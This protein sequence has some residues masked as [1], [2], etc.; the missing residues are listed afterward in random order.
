M[1]HAPGSSSSSPAGFD[2]AAFRSVR[3]GSGL[4]CPRCQGRRV[5]RWG[6]SGRRRRYRCLGCGRTFSDFTGTPLAYLKRIDR[7]P[8]YLRCLERAWPVRGTAL[9]LGLDPCTAF[10]WR[11]RFL[12]HLRDTDRTALLGDVGLGLLRFP[13]SE[14]GRRHAPSR[15]RDDPQGARRRDR[16]QRTG[17]PVRALPRRSVPP[18]SVLPPVSALPPVLVLVAWERDGPIAAGVVG[19]GVAEPERVDRLLRRCLARPVRIATVEGPYGP[20]RRWARG[21]GAPVEVVPSPR[22][23]PIG[24]YGRYLRRWL[25]RFRGVATR[26]LDHYLTWFALRDPAEWGVQDSRPAPRGEARRSRRSSPERWRLRHATGRDRH[27]PPLLGGLARRPAP[28]GGYV[29]NPLPG[30]PEGGRASRPGP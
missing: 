27:H 30:P 26:Y 29:L 23:E 7:V 13:Y 4:A 3:F 17:D 18:V 21:A 9:L 28:D 16:W 20:L 22:L 15:D 5:H 24:T 10:R 8:D 2:F 6:F 1:A 14:K 19:C 12:A 11:H 25:R